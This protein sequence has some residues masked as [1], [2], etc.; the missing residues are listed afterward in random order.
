MYST[1]TTVQT[2]Y[3]WSLLREDVLGVSVKSESHS[4]EA[5]RNKLVNSVIMNTGCGPGSRVSLV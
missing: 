4:E 5:L 3:T 2:V 1:M